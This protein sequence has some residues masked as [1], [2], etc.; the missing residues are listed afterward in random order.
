MDAHE[1]ATLVEAYEKTSA[2][3]WACWR[4]EDDDEYESTLQWMPYELLRDSLE[5]GRGELMATVA[6]S[7]CRCHFQLAHEHRASPG[8]CAS[9]REGDG[10]SSGLRWLPW[11]SYHG[12]SG[13]VP[14]AAS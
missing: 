10:R 14:Q 4:L 2:V 12:Y 6:D 5:I 3:S 1:G 9:I 13:R 8:S 7:L 11:G